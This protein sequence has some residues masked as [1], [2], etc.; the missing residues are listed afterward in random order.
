MKQL[1]M[2]F[3]Y[4]WEPIPWQIFFLCWLAPEFWALGEYPFVCV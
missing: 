1:N 3:Y 4:M 2:Y